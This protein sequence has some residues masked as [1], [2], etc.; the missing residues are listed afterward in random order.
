MGNFYNSPSAE[1]PEYLD[2][3]IAGKLLSLLQSETYERGEAIEEVLLVATSYRNILSENAKL[4]ENENPDC[5]IWHLDCLILEATNMQ[6]DPKNDLFL[7]LRAFHS[8]KE[9]MK[10]MFPFLNVS[11]A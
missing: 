3:R 5:V 2:A 7:Y 11:A 6:N 8:F 4:M 9:V 1:T 10:N